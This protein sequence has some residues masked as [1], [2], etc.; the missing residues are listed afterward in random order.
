MRYSSGQ[1]LPLEEH[2]APVA[3]DRPKPHYYSHGFQWFADNG[4][5]DPDG[6]QA[7]WP[8][9]KLA[10]YIDRQQAAGDYQQL[11]ELYV[12]SYSPDQDWALFGIMIRRSRP[13]AGSTLTVGKGAV[14]C[15]DQRITLWNLGPVGSGDERPPLC[16]GDET[17]GDEA[18]VCVR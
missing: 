6:F 5:T 1:T 15:E 7:Y 13:E 9:R 18:V 2:F 14:R 3:N 4:G 17:A 12:N 10:A 11:A 8:G 16:D